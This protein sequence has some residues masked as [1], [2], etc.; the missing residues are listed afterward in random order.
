M[1]R[2]IACSVFRSVDANS[3]HDCSSAT[4]FLLEVDAGLLER[5][6]IRA[7]AIRHQFFD[8]ILPFSEL[9]RNFNAAFLSRVFV[10]KLSSTSL[11]WSMA[12]QR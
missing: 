9:F 3:P 2:S 12:R 11:W 5:S 1:K 7:A 6:A 8:T 10:T 4:G